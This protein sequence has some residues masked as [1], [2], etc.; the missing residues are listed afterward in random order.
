MG[1]KRNKDKSGNLQNLL[2]SLADILS[3]PPDAFSVLSQC[4]ILLGCSVDEHGRAV[5]DGNRSSS[6]KRRRSNND[7][8][9][10]GPISSQ[11]SGPMEDVN[12]PLPP[13]SII[14]ERTADQV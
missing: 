3:T 14:D 1:K 6:K 9:A 8:C 4:A 2:R 5:Y 7:E 10:P 13:R 12:V 11:V